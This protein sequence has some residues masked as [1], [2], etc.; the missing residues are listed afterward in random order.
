MGLVVRGGVDG[1][2][3]PGG[4]RRQKYYVVHVFVCAEAELQSFRT[5]EQR[6]S[7]GVVAVT[8]CGA[9]DRERKVA[10]RIDR[11]R[12]VLVLSGTRLLGVLHDQLY[13][14]YS[15]RVP[16][17]GNHSTHHSFRLSK[18]LRRLLYCTQQYPVSSLETR[19]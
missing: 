14:T 4:R 16:P 13:C 19:H 10:N 12:L 9:A 7:G 6:D 15:T 18:Q 8:R 1:G 11:F 3:A 17:W 2:D 5:Q